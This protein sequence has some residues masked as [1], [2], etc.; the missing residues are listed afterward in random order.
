VWP[1]GGVLR[2]TVMSDGR[3]VGR[4]RGNAVDLFDDCDAAALAAEQRDVARFTATA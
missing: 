4:W 3:I 1:G 2:P